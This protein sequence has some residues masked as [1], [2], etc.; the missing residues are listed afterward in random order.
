MRTG[1]A[2]HTRRMVAT[3]SLA[4]LSVTGCAADLVAEASEGSSTPTVS[5]SPPSATSAPSVIAQSAVSAAQDAAAPSTQLGVAVLDRATGEIA[6]GS[7][8]SEPFYT[9]SVAKVIVAVDILERRRS[10]GL[11]VSDEDID[12]IRRAL[13][14]S[15]DGAMN[16]LWVKF[17]GA[18]AAARVSARLDLTA[19][20]APD[21]TTQWGEM[22]TSA[23]DMVRVYRHVLEEMP[24][25]DRDLIVAF[26]A[27]A[28]AIAHDGFDQAFALLA[29]DV[30]AAGGLDTIAKQGWMCCFSGQYYLHSAGAVNAEQRFIVVLLSRVPRAPGWSAARAELTAVADAALAVLTRG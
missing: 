15:D 7:R 16:V 8:G 24:S 11:A 28:P 26:L 1:G 9:A 29:P 5:S 14:P 18:G 25:G 19:T 17:D 3:M 4:I 6:V 22:S 10:T 21:D 30:E 13:G 20:S 27:A 12:L 23:T 2:G